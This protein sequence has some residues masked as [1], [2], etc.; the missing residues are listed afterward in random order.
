M[1]SPNLPPE[2]YAVELAGDR[3][4][5]SERRFIGTHPELEEYAGVL[6][7]EVEPAHALVLVLS[8]LPEQS[9]LRFAAAFCSRRRRRYSEPPTTERERLAVAA[10]VSL[11]VLELADRPALRS[12]RLIDLLH[13]AAQGDDLSLT[14]PT[15]IADLRKIVARIRLDV[16]LEDPDDRRAAAAAAVAETIDPSSGAVAL[17]EIL[18]R[19]AWAAVRSWETDRV[20][21]FLLEVDD[22]MGSAGRATPP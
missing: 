17:Q 18:V 14:P 4:W 20:L 21:E 16:E 1:D 7:M 13:G 10:A 2:A 9:R 19:A 12:E 5:H 15:A 6:G 22:L 3:F 11:R 8:Q